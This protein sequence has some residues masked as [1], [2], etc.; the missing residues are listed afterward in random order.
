MQIDQAS[1]KLARWFHLIL[2]SLNILPKASQ[3]QEQ[4]RYDKR[5]ET[6]YKSYRFA[7][8]AYKLEPWVNTFYKAG[9]NNKKEKTIPTNIGDLLIDSFSIAI[10]FLG[11]GWF[12]G[13]NVG[14]AAGSLSI[15]ECELLQSCLYNN[16]GLK[17][18]LVLLD[19]LKNNGRQVHRFTVKSESYSAFYNLVNPYIE[20]LVKEVGTIDKDQF[21]KR[22]V[23][24]KPS[25]T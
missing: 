2:N 9:K 19:P 6:T 4:L 24:P 22:K 23:L 17:T 21:L 3:I 13:D 5:Y 7:T 16:F 14:F 20:Q 15:S 8:R 12:D 18:S 1:E 11:D 10:W 25:K